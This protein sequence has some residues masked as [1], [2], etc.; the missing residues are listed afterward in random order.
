MVLGNIEGIL[1]RCIFAVFCQQSGLC[2]GYRIEDTRTPD[3]P[4]PG[5]AYVPQNLEVI[6]LFHMMEE[7]Q[8]MPQIK[9]YVHDHDAKTKKVLEKA[10]WT[11]PENIDRGH[12]FKSFKKMLANGKFGNLV[13]ECLIRWMR[14]LVQ[15]RNLS[16]KVKYDAWMNTSRHLTGDHRN[17]IIDHREVEPLIHPDDKAFIARL[18]IFLENTSWI[19]AKCDSYF[20]TQINESFNRGKLAYANKDQKWGFTWPGRMACAVLDRNYPGWKLE[21]RSRLCQLLG[22]PPLSEFATDLLK[23]LEAQRLD[24]KEECHSEQY[25]KRSR[26]EKKALAEALKAKLAKAQANGRKLGYKRK[27]KTTAGHYPS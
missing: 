4:D 18:D 15:A 10:G 27:P 16:K 20:S 8:Q 9:Q 21:L 2:I 14:T 6:A 3:L 23:I 25:R 11:I 5:Y 1:S 22:L 24:R 13:S 12:A 17:C 19:L 26:D 7:L